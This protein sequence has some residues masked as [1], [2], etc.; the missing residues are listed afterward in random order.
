VVA[1]LTGTRANDLY[2][3]LTGRKPRR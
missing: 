2:K 1:S 3:A